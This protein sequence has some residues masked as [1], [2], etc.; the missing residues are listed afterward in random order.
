MVLGTLS[1]LRSIWS[2]NTRQKWWPSTS[3]KS[4][5]AIYGLVMWY[6]I[7][8]LQLQTFVNA[9]FGSASIVGIGMPHDQVVNF[10]GRFKLPQ[11]VSAVEPQ[12]YFGGEVRKESG[13][14]YAYVALAVEGRGYENLIWFSLKIFTKLE[15]ALQ[16]EQ[17]EGNDCSSFTSPCFGFWTSSE[18]RK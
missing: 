2:G 6:F 11:K 1:T 10:A 4:S 5:V 3:T 12:K 15:Y 8:W 13:G 7:L 18:I 9:N 16:L 14:N 17:S